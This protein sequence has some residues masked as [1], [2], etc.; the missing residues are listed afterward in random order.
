MCMYNYV[1][2]FSLYTHPFH[3]AVTLNMH[4]MSN[5]CPTWTMSSSRLSLCGT[6]T[7]VAASPAVLTIGCSGRDMP[8]GWNLSSQATLVSICACIGEYM[9]KNYSCM[10]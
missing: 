3:S 9:H 2:S 7:K 1:Y 10:E 6:S 5:E 4:T 8:L